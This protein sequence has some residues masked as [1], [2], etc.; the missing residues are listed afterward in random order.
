MKFYLPNLYPVWVKK[1]TL[2]RVFL[3]KKPDFCGGLDFQDHEIKS[4]LQEIRSPSKALK[5]QS[6]LI[7]F[8]FPLMRLNC[9]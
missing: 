4:R 7:G 6:R 1:N 9:Q 3:S 8:Q 2:Y 5:E